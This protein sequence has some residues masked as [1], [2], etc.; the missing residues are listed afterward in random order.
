MRKGLLIKGLV[1]ICLSEYIWF[2]FTFTNPLFF[3]VSAIVGVYGWKS[4]FS[5]FDRFYTAWKI[6]NTRCFY[7]EQYKAVINIIHTPTGKHY[8]W[9]CENCNREGAE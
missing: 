5:S 7:C 8:T 2:S 6:H 4:I 9:K 3:I 1:A